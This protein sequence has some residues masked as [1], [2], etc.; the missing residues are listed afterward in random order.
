M[1]ILTVVAIAL[2]CFL[3]IKALEQNGNS[4]I[5]V[6]NHVITE[7][8]DLK[9]H[10]KER[11]ARANATEKVVQL[12]KEQNMEIK[13]SLKQMKKDRGSNVWRRPNQE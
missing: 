12:L 2:S 10:V 11:D 8:K 13:D 5:E 6:L 1:K 3:M 9:Q 4:I 7:L